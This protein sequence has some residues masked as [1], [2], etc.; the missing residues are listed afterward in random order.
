MD[1]YAYYYYLHTLPLRTNSI[2][3][4]IDAIINRKSMTLYV[5][6]GSILQGSIENA[7]RQ[8]IVSIVPVLFTEGFSSSLG[9]RLD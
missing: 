3:V 8:D 6:E 1:A 9:K 5:L 7:E 4:I 2:E